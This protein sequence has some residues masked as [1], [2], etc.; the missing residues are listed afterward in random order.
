MFLQK[1]IQCV[2]YTLTLSLILTLPLTAEEKE[3]EEAGKKIQLPSFV[4]VKPE[5]EGSPDFYLGKE[6]GPHL[7]I[8]SPENKDL[9][10]SLG[11]RFMGTAEYKSE[12]VPEG[13]DSWD[14]YARRVRL[15]VGASFSK[16]IKFIMD[17]RNDNANRGDS[18]ERDF[19]VGDAKVTIKHLWEE[20]WLNAAFF[21]AKVDVSRSET[22]KSAHL[23]YY[24]RAKVADSAANWVSHNRRA[25]NA[26]LFGDFDKKFHYSFAVGDGVQ[27]GSFDDALGENAA[28]I[29]SQSTPMF[30]GKLRLSPFDGWEEVERTETYFGQGKHFSVGLGAFATKGIDVEAPGGQTIKVDRELVNAELSAHYHGAFLQA[31]YFD[32]G[33]AIAD[34][35][36]STLAEGDADGWYVLGEYTIAELAY[37]SP[38][39]RF[40]QWDRFSDRDGYEHDSMSAG[41]N[42]YLR[43]NNTKIGFVYQ[44]DEYGDA[45]GDPDT[46]T[47]RIVSQLFF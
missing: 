6:T 30:G 15:E 17:I 18:G 8:R 9:S 22:I 44:R 45:I 46:D 5:K 3:E 42:W 31:E 10:F 20:D 7:H 11:I 35:S 37:L 14:F 1:S 38:F 28:S 4:I 34:F 40:E 39:V 41:I 36:E 47:F 24:D 21:R 16:D 23:V 33:G 26:Q 2:L 27:S 32:F 29:G 13:D 43:G 12:D 19:N 25:M